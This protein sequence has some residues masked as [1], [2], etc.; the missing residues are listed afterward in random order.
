MY[1]FYDLLT[2]CFHE[3]RN[4]RFHELLNFSTRLHIQQDYFD[5]KGENKKQKKKGD[6]VFL[7]R[8]QNYAQSSSWF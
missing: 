6:S 3:E 2:S 4:P 7:R 5:K 8:P 1:L